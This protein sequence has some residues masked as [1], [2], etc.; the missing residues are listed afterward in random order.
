M[1]RAF[2]TSSY[3][4]KKLNWRMNGTTE[5]VEWAKRSFESAVDHH[6]KLA[7][8]IDSAVINGNPHPTPKTGDTL[9]ASIA[10]GTEDVTGKNRVVS[11]HVYPDGTVKFSKDYADVNVGR[12]PEAPAGEGPSK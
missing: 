1:S 3:Y 5:N 4:L 9:H 10:A 8:K 11:A 7:A 6:P 2:S 12:D